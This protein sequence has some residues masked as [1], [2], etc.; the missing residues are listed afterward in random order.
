VSYF[1]YFALPMVSRPLNSRMAAQALLPHVRSFAPDI[2]LSYFL[3]PEGFAALQIANA[4]SVPVVAKALGSDINRIGDPVSAMLTRNVL[5]NADFLLA[6]S[7]DIRKK[8][9]SMGAPPGKIRTT[10]NGCD[11]SVFHVKDRL[12]ARNEL[13]ID[14]TSEAVV[15]IG[16]MDVKKGLRELV[17]AAAALRSARPRLQ[18]YLV[19]EGPDRPIIEEAIR[20]KAA[21]SYI[22]LL[23]GCAF[24]VVATWMAASDLVTLPSYM[25]G[26]PNVVLEALACGR[27]VVATNVGGVPEIMSE[28]CGRLV[29]PCDSTA[30]AQ[31]LSSVLDKKWDADAI[32]KRRSRSW[33]DVAMELLEVFESLVSTRPG[34]AVV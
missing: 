18:V 24:N 16:R 33:G 25:E 4:L 10:I 8:A 22:H 31:A 9:I 15:Q 21:A 32:S 12:R 2:I 27:P 17:E 1:D 3:Y 5:R 26:C 7:D 20:S 28:D 23:P 6:V 19:G 13:G 11:S 30:L 34:P 14:A 29:P